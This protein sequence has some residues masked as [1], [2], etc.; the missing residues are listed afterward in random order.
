MY[1]RLWQATGAFFTICT[2]RIFVSE[3]FLGKTE[4]LANRTVPVQNYITAVLVFLVVEMLMT[5]G[6][7]GT[8]SPVPSS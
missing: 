3:R 6:F 2:V 8:V 5:W 7:Y 4:N 1:T